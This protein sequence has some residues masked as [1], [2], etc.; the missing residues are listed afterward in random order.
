MGLLDQ[1]AYFGTDLKDQGFLVF[2]QRYILQ[3]SQQLE[4]LTQ[5]KK[6]QQGGI[7]YFWPNLIRQTNLDRD[8]S[9]INF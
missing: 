7:G 4:K 6:K 1:F 8:Y 3:D 2:K 9:K 5:F